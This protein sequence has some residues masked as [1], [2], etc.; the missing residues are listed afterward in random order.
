MK[1]KK[2]NEVGIGSKNGGR[3]V[4]GEKGGRV[5]EKEGVGIF[6]PTQELRCGSS[7]SGPGFWAETR[8]AVSGS[9]C[10]PKVV[11]SRDYHLRH[12]AILPVFWAVA[13]GRR[14]G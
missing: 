9:D 8:L 4:E 14:H 5:G 11:M 6:F 7:R 10:E 2:R 12:L 13:R 1:K 3:T